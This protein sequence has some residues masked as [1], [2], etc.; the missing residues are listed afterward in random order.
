MMKAKFA[1]KCYGCNKKYFGVGDE[2]EK[3]GGWCLVGCEVCAH[4]TKALEI[5]KA[6]ECRMLEKH[7]VLFG[8]D[9][10]GQY[11]GYQSTGSPGEFLREAIKYGEVTDEEAVEYEFWYTSRG[12]SG[13]W[14]D[15]AE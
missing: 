8:Y 4:R 9:F 13:M 14:R 12:G 15:L 10:G 5:V 6:V 3:H 1:G 2:I 7:H 11:P